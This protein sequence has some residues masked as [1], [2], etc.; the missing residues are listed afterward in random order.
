M[1]GCCLHAAR[2]W[3]SRIQHLPDDFSSPELTLRC[4]VLSCAICMCHC[5][6]V[7][8]KGLPVGLLLM[9]QRL[10]E[11]STAKKAAA[12]AAA[13]PAGSKGK[14]GK[15]QPSQATPAPTAAATGADPAE[16][17]QEVWLAELMASLCEKVGGCHTTVPKAMRC[18]PI[19]C[20]KHR[21][22]CAGIT[23]MR[24]Y[25]VLLVQCV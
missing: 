20:R 2:P 14:K 25:V 6:H 12:S 17:G 4:P 10:V 1:A 21:C 24:R 18:S 22:V 8:D 15:K 19:V 9:L 11:L 13:T 5:H 23:V 7:Q 16:D 3:H